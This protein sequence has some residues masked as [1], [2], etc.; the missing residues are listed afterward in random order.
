[1]EKKTRYMEAGVRLNVNIVKIKSNSFL[2][3][4]KLSHSL[5]GLLMDFIDIRNL[6]F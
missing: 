5:R 6:I 2:N 3:Q 4:K 1:M